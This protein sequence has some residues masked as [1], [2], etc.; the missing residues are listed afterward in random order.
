MAGKKKKRWGGG[1]D[2][3]KKN[4]H[5]VEKIGSLEL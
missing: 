3:V 2:D 1:D 4:V 5:Q